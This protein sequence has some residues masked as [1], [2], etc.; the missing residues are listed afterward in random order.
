M[1]VQF[2]GYLRHLEGGG[3]GGGEEKEVLRKEGREE[4]E[5]E[6]EVEGYRENQK[7]TEAP[8]E[9]GFNAVCVL[10]LTVFF[11]FSLPLF[12]P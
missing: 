2:V 3:G 1:D 5:E 8:L 6:G 12:M 10:G 11:S 9:Q 4:K 7:E